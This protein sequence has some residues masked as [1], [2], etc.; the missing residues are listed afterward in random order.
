VTKAY[1]IVRVDVRDPE[2]YKKYLAANAAAFRK[3]G[4]RFLV[5]GG[6]TEVKSGTA[7]AR[8]VVMEFKDYD[9][10]VACYHSPEYQHAIAE[11]GFSADVDL[12]VIGGYDGPQPADG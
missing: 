2:T 4:G 9:T 1:W 12:I 8:N 10:A 11:R 7:R 3:Y 6:R 5:R